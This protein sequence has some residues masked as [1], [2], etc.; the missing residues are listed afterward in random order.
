[1]HMH[2]TARANQKM[3]RACKE[4]KEAS[5]IPQELYY[6]GLVHLV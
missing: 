6:Y 1:M 4:V 2:T 3:S 5:G